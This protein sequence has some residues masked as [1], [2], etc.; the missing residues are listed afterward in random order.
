MLLLTRLNGEHLTV[1]ATMIEL[2]ERTP[3]T[4]ITLVSGRKLMVLESA[5]EVVDRITD[6]YG[7]IGLIGVQPQRWKEPVDHES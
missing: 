6:Y 7:K 2:V 1:N 5:E 4:V 3:D